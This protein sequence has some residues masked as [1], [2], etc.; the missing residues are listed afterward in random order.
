MEA[1]NIRENG[2]KPGSG[3]EG[4]PFSS[5]IVTL[6][7]A[8]SS[9]LTIHHAIL[10]RC[11]KLRFYP[12]T[13]EVDL[14]R[15][16]STAG[17]SLVEYLYADKYGHSQG[18]GF[19]TSTSSSLSQEIRLRELKTKLEVYRLARAVELNGLEEMAK[20]DIERSAQGLDVFAVIDAVKEAYPTPA[21]DDAWFEHWIK[22]LI[23][24]AF[25]NPARL[26][27]SEGAAVRDFGDDESVVKVLF[28]CM[29]ETY[30]DMVESLARPDGSAP[31]GPRGGESH[32]MSDNGGRL[33]DEGG[34]RRV[35][36]DNETNDHAGRM[37]TPPGSDAG[38]TGRASDSGLHEPMDDG[39]PE[40]APESEPV[41]EPEPEPEVEAE[42]VPELGPEIEPEPAPKFKFGNGARNWMAQFGNGARNWMASTEEQAP[43]TLDLSKPAPEET[44][45]QEIAPA[46][47]QPFKAG[48][49]DASSGIAQ[50]S[51]KSKKKKKARSTIA[52]LGSC[53]TT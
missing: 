26:L 6:E 4:S 49:N 48:D 20:H 41:L 2:P 45:P 44:V 35:D 5:P 36:K 13:K 8:D 15:F 1:E 50:S 17:H 37:Y 24:K 12:Y 31:Q 21:R 28:R 9:P 7:F 14:G 53:D 16:S 40:P 22:T 30:V 34:E 46:S 19:S 18:E 43:S 52:N 39:E 32:C 38:V 23:K 47:E 29:L 10:L 42:P 51:K 3:F 27:L 25:A 11:P 33:G